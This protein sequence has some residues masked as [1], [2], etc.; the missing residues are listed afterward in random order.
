MPNCFISTYKQTRGL[1]MEI[2]VRN[3]SLSNM[4]PSC[5]IWL[6]YW[7]L[8]SSAGCDCEQILENLFKK[9]L[10]F[11]P[12]ITDN[13]VVNAFYRCM[14]TIKCTIERER[15]R[16][17]YTFCVCSFAYQCA[18]RVAIRLI[19]VHSHS[20]IYMQYENFEPRHLLNLFQPQTWNQSG[21]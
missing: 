10:F 8:R 9:K 17:K 4:W 13:S 2:K 19:K 7:S 12:I 3:I 16:K 18:R 6:F 14:N 1:T 20:Q 15:E 11:N 21:H 5:I